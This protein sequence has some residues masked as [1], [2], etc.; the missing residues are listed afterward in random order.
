MSKSVIETGEHQQLQEL[1]QA[2]I[3]EEETQQAAREHVA[4]LPTLASVLP[5]LVHRLERRECAAVFVFDASRLAGWE[6]QYGA[7]AFEKIMA[8]SREE[9][10]AAVKVHLE[11]DSIV[12]MDAEG[13]DAIL[14]FPIKR[15][16]PGE[17][18]FVDVEDQLHRINSTLLERFGSYPLWFHEA[19]E[20]IVSGSAIILQNGPVDPRRTTYRAIRKAHR[21][22]QIAYGELQ[23][24]RNR[25]VGHVIAHQKLRTLFQPIIDLRDKDQQVF[26]YEALSRPL[27]REA[28][29]LGVHLFVA[30]ARAELDGELDATC[31]ALSFERR[32]TLQPHENL[33]VNCLP[34][35]FYDEMTELEPLLRLWEESGM[36]PAQLVFEVTE[37][38]TRKQ[39]DRIMANVERLRARGY[40]FALDDV[41]TGT[42]NLQL[43]AE[44]EPDFIKMDMSLTIGIARSERKQ[45]LANYLLELSRRCDASLIAEGIETR[46]DLEVLQDLG[47]DFGQGFLLGRPQDYSTV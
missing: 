10:L 14:V 32:P 9:L 33:F 16:R 27:M 44:L 1:S 15:V 20:S 43:L 28:R 21:D 39:V 19:F 2:V 8:L 38:I 11:P 35:T 37:S 47:V 29:K 12:C 36:Q 3:H 40:R 24:R 25:I 18:N 31:R 30:A 23:R 45:R 41:G 26:G 42:S 5:Q 22:A 4:D 46:E 17:S 13:G 7:S 34:P 6:R